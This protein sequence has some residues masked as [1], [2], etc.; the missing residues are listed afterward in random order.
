MLGLDVVVCAVPAAFVVGA[1]IVC[2]PCDAR[3]MTRCVAW[4]VAYVVLVRHRAPFAMGDVAALAT[5]L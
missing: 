5:L 1:T 3:A 4:A 2:P